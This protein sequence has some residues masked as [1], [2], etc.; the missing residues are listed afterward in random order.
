[1]DLKNKINEYFDLQ[2]E[3]YNYFGYQEDWVTI[4]LDYN[5]DSYWMLTGDKERDARVVWSDEPLTKESI[6][7]GKIY[8]GVIYTQRFLPKWVY[9][10]DDFTMVS[11]DTRCDGNKFLMVFDNSK[12]CNDNSLCELYV[13]KWGSI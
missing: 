4:P 11:V 3:I 1:M 13:K 7:S 10:T 8:S 5:L 6:E 2:K 9:R 12:E